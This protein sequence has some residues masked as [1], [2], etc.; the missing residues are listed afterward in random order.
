MTDTSATKPHTPQS[1]LARFYEAERLYMTNPTDPI[2]ISALNAT[3]SQNVKLIQTP[4]LPYGGIWEG[5]T[6]FQGWSTQ[7]SELFDIVDVQDPLVFSNEQSNKVIIN[8]QV[9]FRV[10]KTQKELVYPMCQVVVV[11]SEEGVITEI[12]P[13]YWDVRGLLQALELE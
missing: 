3:L 12:Q 5:I 1:I 9:K 11:D 4:A 8:A 10:R 6:G 13:F 7:M 2:N